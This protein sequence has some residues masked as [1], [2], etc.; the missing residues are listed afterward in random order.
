MD[1]AATQQEKSLSALMDIVT[2]LVVGL[3]AGLSLWL[4]LG[5]G[6][7]LAIISHITG[8]PLCL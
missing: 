8:L 4:W 3:I 1:N 2:A 5:T 6:E 7:S